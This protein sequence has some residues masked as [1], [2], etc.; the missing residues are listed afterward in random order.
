MPNYLDTVADV[1][2][3]AAAR[4][5]AKLCCTASPVWRLPDLVIPP[6]M[7]EMNY[8]CGST[9]DPR[10]L[11]RDDTILYVGVG[12]GLE[13]LQF[14]YCTRRPGS[15]IAVDP[16]PA[17]R[18]RA[19]ANFEEAAR[20]NAWFRP[21]FITLLDG[22]ALDLPVANNTATVLAQNCLFNVFT[23]AD[24]ERALAETIRVLKVGGVFSTSDP[25]TPV[26]L[27]AELTNDERLRA[28]CISGCQTLDDYLAALT[29]A[30]FG[31]VDVRAR[32]PYRLLDPK[33]YPSLKSPVLLESVEVAAYKVPEGEDGPAIFTGRTAIYCGTR[34]AIDDGHGNMLPHG[35][36]VSVSDAAAARLSKLSEVVVTP[37]T[38]HSRGGCC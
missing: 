3:E 13:A 7:L 12:G 5:D 14:A 33:E 17:M 11:R 29:E 31:R 36:P 19:R 22:S 26:P 15:V 21:E 6:I 34:E 28:K 38:W 2:A 25:V 16:V 35:I 24:L 27:P 37:P 10:D 20:L 32:I 8:G 18:E 9:V 4:P 23:A 30:G 1:Y